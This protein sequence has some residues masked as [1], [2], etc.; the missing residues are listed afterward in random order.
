MTTLTT[1]GTKQAY[2]ATRECDARTAITRGLAEYLEGLTVDSV[3]GRRNM[4]RKV[5]QTWAEP[6]DEAV[7][8]SAVVLMSGSASYDASRFTPGVATSEQLPPPDSRYVSAVAEMTGEITVELWC[9][10]PTARAE[11]TAALEEALIPYD[12]MYGLMLDLPHYY[13]VRAV[14]ELKSVQYPD[15]ETTAMQRYRK[16]LLTLSAQMP[17]VRLRSFPLA[18]PRPVVQVNVV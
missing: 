12:E 6:E 2:S 9:N 7:F 5:Y 14:Y 4:L 13:G 16:A 18:R 11:L 3:G 8:P 10:D 17:V 1:L 15:N